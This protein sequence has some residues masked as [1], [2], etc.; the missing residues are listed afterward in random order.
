[1][2]QAE[3]CLNIALGLEALG[4]SIVSSGESTKHVRRILPSKH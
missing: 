3:H 4:D 2:R 1:M